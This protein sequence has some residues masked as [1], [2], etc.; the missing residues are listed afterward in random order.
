M[1]VIDEGYT[2]LSSFPVT[3][4]Y[5]QRV[6]PQYGLAPFLPSPLLQQAPSKQVL[7]PNQ[8]IFTLVPVEKKDPQLQMIERILPD[9]HLQT[10][11]SDAY[12]MFV[13]MPETIANGLTGSSDFTFSDKMRLAKIPY[14]LGGAFLVSGFLAGGNKVEATRQAVAVVFYLAFM[15]MTKAGI[16]LS[17]KAA[18]DLN[19]N[20]R[21]MTQ[22][23]RSERVF[24]SADFPRFDL[25]KQ[26]DYERYARG[27]GIPED[28]NDLRG[29]VQE[30]L[31]KAIVQSRTLKIVLGNLFAVL[32][33][34]FLSRTDMWFRSFDHLSNMPQILMS[35]N[36]GIPTKMRMELT[37]IQ[38]AVLDPIISKLKPRDMSKLQRYFLYGS[39][40]SAVYGLS[41]ILSLKHSPQNTNFVPKKIT[42]N[43][44][45]N[46]ENQI[47]GTT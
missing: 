18:Y 30:R 7:L 20:R 41:K 38:A 31:K 5:Y 34:G 29:A 37:S 6:Q 9:S 10:V 39:L 12:E 4:A 21:Y 1:S 17:Y 35:K 8:E 32:G 23:G 3:A 14:Y 45:F 2:I 13:K 44:I 40:L 15:A 36:L 16:N 26:E 22:T 24:E 25:L 46:A 28:V 11:A 27:F 33:A 42:E 47:G 19:L 43:V